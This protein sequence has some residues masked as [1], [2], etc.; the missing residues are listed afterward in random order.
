MFRISNWNASCQLQMKL[1]VFDNLA[2]SIRLYSMPI[3]N[4]PIDL[5]YP[6]IY[7]FP[8]TIMYQNS[9]FTFLQDIFFGDHHEY[10]T[11]SGDYNPYNWVSSVR[12]VTALIGYEYNKAK[13]ASVKSCRTNQ[14]LALGF[15]NWMDYWCF[16]TYQS[17]KVYIGLLCAKID[18]YWLEG[19]TQIY[20]QSCYV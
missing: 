9:Q 19:I 7:S 2:K 5:I 13:A 11:V 15:R 14:W 16:L 20:A 18:H 3:C 6:T 8:G 1:F 10:R 4:L 12:S 17:Q